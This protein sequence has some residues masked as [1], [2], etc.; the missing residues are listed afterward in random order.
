MKTVILTET[1]VR[2]VI[3]RI[4][5]EQ[6]SVRTESLSVDLGA[7]WP[8]GK[9]KMTPQQ[10]TN[11]E[12][13]LREIADFVKKNKDSVVTIQ[14]ESGES[15]VTNYDRE[16]SG[17]VKLD[18]G[19]LSQRR[20]EQLVTY[21]T[22]FFQKLVDSGVITKL[23][24]FPTPI[25]KIGTTDYA[26]PQDLKDPSKKQKYDQ[27]QYVKAI[28]SLK[29]DYECLVGMEITI[30]YYAGKNRS[31][32]ECDEAIFELRMN[33][34][35]LGIVNLNNSSLDMGYDYVMNRYKKDQ[36]RYDKSVSEFERLV[37]SG[38]YKE[39]ERKKILPSETPTPK[40]P[41]VFRQRASEMG[42]ETVE[43]FIDE[44]NKINNSFKE[45]GR[46]SDGKSGGNRSQTFILDGARAKSIIDNSPSDKIVL[47]IIPLV[48][49]DGK[50]KIF[51][52]T[53]THA[54]TPWVTIKSRK[55]ETP[56][57]NGEPNIGMKRGSTA[58]TILLT[59]DLCGN[60]IVK[61]K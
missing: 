25:A 36:E 20:G 40:W 51:Y 8:S 2:N 32:H 48:S 55:S 31:Q 58:E 35:S 33:G 60:P 44:L 49:K 50:Y 46:K 30:G 45:Y 34:V 52:K 4:I 59:T 28:I 39:R 19:V 9:W 26:G 43:P 61:T 17:N 7:A 27:E 24:V 21:L 6:N 12:G 57:F 1:Q 47:S 37:A 56:L 11:I 18:P 16:V 15:K 54:D 53:G 23:P 38:V 14:I 42:Y 5:N 10:M 22:G 13:K 41:L 29:K 3:D